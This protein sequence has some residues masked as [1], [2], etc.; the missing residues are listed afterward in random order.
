MRRFLKVLAVLAVMFL[1]SGNASVFAD[2][3]A[4]LGASHSPKPITGSIFPD[5]KINDDSGTE[6]Q[7]FPALAMNKYGCAVA[8]WM[9]QRNGSKRI[10]AQR[11]SRFG[12]PDGTNFQVHEYAGSSEQ[13][14]P[15]VAIDNRG[16]FV[17]VWEDNSEGHFDVRA[18]L[19]AANGAPLT[20]C[21]IVNN[22]G[23]LNDRVEPAVAMDSLGNFVVCWEDHR[24]NRYDIFAQ[25]YD[26]CG[27]SQGSNLL[28]SDYFSWPRAN[29]AI[30]MHIGGDFVI[31]WQDARNG[32]CDDIYAQRYTKNGIALG[33]NFEVSDH[34]YQELST[35]FPAVAVQKNG[36]FLITWAYGAL[37]FIRVY[38]A[39]GTPKIALSPITQSA[40]DILS[41]KPDV[42]IN[43]TGGYSVVWQANW[44]GN[45]DIY[46]RNFEAD[47]TPLGGASVL[48]NDIPGDQAKPCIAVDDR[49]IGIALWEDD[50][51]G[52]WD[53]YG[54]W[55]GALQPLNV[56]A[57]SGFDSM[58]PISWSHVYSVDEIRKY[59]I[60]RSLT[61]GGSYS[62]VASIDL[63]TRGVLGPLMRDWID[64]SV[65]NGTT[66]YYVVTAVVSDVESPASVE[67]SA[68]PAA[69]LH[70]YQSAWATTAPD[71]D[72]EI[73]AGEWDDATPIQI[74]CPLVWSP[75]TLLVKNDENHL[76]LAVDD[77]NDEIIDPGNYLGILFDE[78]H[79]STWDISSPSNEG[80]ITISN[81][82]A[83]FTGYW[84]TYPNAFGAS[85]PITAAGTQRAISTASGH[86]QYEVAFD[87]STSPLNA[88]PGE[89]IGVGFWLNDPG[90]FYPTHYGYT[91]E[92]PLGLL[93]EA[94]PP[95]GNLVL[96]EETVN[97]PETWNFTSAT[98][99]SAIII[100]PTSANPNIDG[101][102]LANGDYVGVFT[103][104]GL[105][106]GWAV[107]QS[108]NMSLTVWGDD[109]VTS[110]IDGFIVGEQ[111]YY[112]VFEP[113]ISKEWINVS[114]DYSLEDGTY[115]VDGISTLSQFDVLSATVLTLNLN[116][117]WN[118]FSVNVDPTDP[119]LES[120]FNPIIDQLVIVKNNAGQSYIPAY[121][122]N[123][124]GDID[125]KEGYQASLSAASSLDITGLPVAPDTPIDLAAGWSMISYLPTT[126]ID[127]AT[128]LSSI[129]GQLVIAKNNAGRSY[130]PAYSINT[131]GEMQVG[132]GY[133]VYLNAAGTL[134]YPATSLAANEMAATKSTEKASA[135]HFQYTSVTGEN[136]TIIL[137]LTI[138]PK[139]SDGNLVE[140]GDGIGIFN[141]SGICCGAAVWEGC[142]IA[143]TIWGDDSQTEAVDGFTSGEALQFRLWRTSVDRE[144]AVNVEYAENQPA[145]YGANGFAVLS[146]FEALTTADVAGADQAEIPTEFRLLQNYPNPFNPETTIEYH[147]PYAAGVALTIFDL[148][149]QVV[150]HL[151]SGSKPAGRYSIGW[152]GRDEFDHLVASGMYFYRLQINPA[153]SNQ[154][155]ISDIKKMILMK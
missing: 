117:G 140:T 122:I 113:D 107:W 143:I 58:V 18:R 30:D 6:D 149:G 1:L 34:P 120:V 154:A 96:A 137:P 10:F 124:I 123:I 68:T 61:S 81:A 84:G 24:H 31:V 38:N 148:H 79:N 45:W 27:N 141:S 100:L 39:D 43:N 78:D 105:C 111:F 41:G 99:S 114:V 75:V 73:S 63:T 153:N 2:V 35:W 17:V 20:D 36:E 44:S 67:V 85:T 128:A 133:Q 144:Y 64:M 86:V 142:N 88:L 147:L 89:T 74:A 102:P 121:S 16:H 90:N 55:L 62:L 13:R 139:C 52:N 80:L 69:G 5:F 49:G 119:T 28:V 23:T 71:I 145:I 95:L 51:N 116:Q 135:N 130:I 136:A 77:L 22:D 101:T 37:V 155:A 92:L 72:G 57:G 70:T 118:M 25:R 48:V 56:H 54:G 97:L 146:K 150:R 131:I 151:A 42:C 19:F 104:A 47:G 106:C 7:E 65:A 93:W 110:E 98:G 132:Q 134:I 40:V 76:Y 26:N 33:D 32:G 109:D 9:D 103:P 60:Y 21:F 94:A 15:D 115:A 3:N 11:S 87:L 66:Y 8:V 50:R 53:I 83:L 126:P 138:K 59:K 4:D 29:A 129:S 14:K 125:F 12:L 127:A 82:A 91:A 46:A 108:E 112:R 152:N